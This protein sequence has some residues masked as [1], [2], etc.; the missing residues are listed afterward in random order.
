MSRQRKQRRGR[1]QQQPTKRDP[2][3]PPTKTFIV[4]RYEVRTPPGMTPEW[5]ARETGEMDEGYA[6]QL[7]EGTLN[8]L[9]NAGDDFVSGPPIRDPYLVRVTTYEEQ[10]TPRLEDARRHVEAN[11]AKNELIRAEL[12]RHL[13]AG[14][15]VEIGGGDDG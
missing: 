1:P 3:N 2:L 5:V 10:L 15:A 11:R 7:L 13:A 12:E 8:E 6:R 9:E 14:G 4:M